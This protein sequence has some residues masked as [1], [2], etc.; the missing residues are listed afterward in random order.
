MGCN[1]LTES[2]ATGATTVLS[3]FTESA[4]TVVESVAGV[5]VV[6]PF[7]HATNDVAISTNAKITFFICLFLN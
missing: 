7:V 3:T 2:A 6:A 1:Y 5:S 4:A